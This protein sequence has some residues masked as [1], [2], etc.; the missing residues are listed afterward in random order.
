MYEKLNN[1]VLLFVEILH[2]YYIFKINPSHIQNLYLKYDC[3]SQNEYRPSQKHISE[4]TFLFHS[5]NTI[6]SVT[7]R[8]E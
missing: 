8:H 1:K 7:F 2:D 4:N 6:L 3:T 5:L